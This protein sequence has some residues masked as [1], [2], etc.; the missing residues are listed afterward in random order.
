MSKKKSKDIFI[1]K[2]ISIGNSKGIVLPKEQAKSNDINLGDQVIV[3][4]RKLNL[5]KTFSEGT[6]GS[7]F[8]LD[9]FSPPLTP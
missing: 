6:M 7:L 3:R 2:V 4:Y 1:G 5:E 8:T 9:S